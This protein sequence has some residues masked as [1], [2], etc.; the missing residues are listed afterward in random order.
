MGLGIGL[1]INNSR[2][3]LQGLTR[4]VGAFERTPKYSIESSSDTWRTKKYRVGANLGTVLEGI[5]ALWFV[6]AFALALQ[7][8][9]WSS[10]PFLYLFLQG[11]CYMYGL[12]L[13]AGGWRLRN[14]SAPATAAPASLD[15]RSS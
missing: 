11:Y 5:L 6:V 7:W 15:S 3:V 13:F 9:M 12:S 14:R 4:E 2:A 1:A 8:G 10:L